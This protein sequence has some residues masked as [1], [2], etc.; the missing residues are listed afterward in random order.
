MPKPV[1]MLLPY[2]FVIFMKN[3]NKNEKVKYNHMIF[4]FLNYM[5]L[6]TMVLTNFNLKTS[7]NH[8]DQQ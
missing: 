2:N 4:F 1:P 7:V 6:L 8:L 3:I 5:N